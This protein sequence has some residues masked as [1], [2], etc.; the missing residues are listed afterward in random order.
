MKLFFFKS[1]TQL[2]RT[3]QFNAAP[4][5]APPDGAPP[6]LPP[7]DF[8]HWSWLRLDWRSHRMEL[9]AIGLAL[10]VALML[11]PQV[12]N[13]SRRDDY[14]RIMQPLAWGW[15]PLEAMEYRLYDGRFSARGPVVPESKKRIAI[16]AID[17]T[18]LD[19]LAE[20]PWPRNWHARLIGRLKK[21]GAR[22]IVWDVNFAAKQNPQPGGALSPAD[23]ALV[24]ASAEAGNVLISAGFNPQLKSDGLGGT[25][26]TNITAL[27]FDDLDATTPDVGFNWLPTNSSG[28]TRR[29]AWRANVSG[30]DVAGLATLAVGLDAGKLDDNENA[31]FFQQLKSNRWPDARGEVHRV[32]LSEMKIGRFDRV[33]TAPIFFWGPPGTFDTYGYSDVLNGTSGAWSEAALRQK[34]DGRIVFI[35]ATA[36][37]LKDLFVSPA[38]AISEQDAL[39]GLGASRESQVAGV[40]LHAG[41]AAQ[42][43]DG[44]YIHGPRTQSTLA[45]LFGLCVGGA[46]WLAF[47]RRW[48][49]R[50]ARMAQAQWARWRAPGRLHGV[51][52]FG[53]YAMLGGL[54]SL[55]FWQWAQWQFAQRDV[56]IVMIY[57]L[58]GTIA[59]SGLT[60][61]LFFVAEAGERRK[62]VARLSRHV[63]PDV[64]NHVLAHP[65]EENPRPFNAN[66]T[67]LFSDLEGFT[68]Y[69]TSHDA[70]EV[71]EALNSYMTRMVAVVKSHGG[72]L[73]KFMGDGI[74]AFFGAP[75]PRWDHAAQALTCAIAMQNEC[76]RFREETG[77]DFY[78][79]IGVHTGEVIVGYMGS[80]ERA[81]YTVLGDSVNLASRL[82]AKNK[83]LGAR[84]ICS[85]DTYVAAAGAVVASMER[86]T[87]TGLT[88]LIDV[89]IVRGLSGTLPQEERWQR[90]PAADAP[91]EL[92][93]GSASHDASPGTLEGG[94][95]ALMQGETQNRAPDSRQDGPRQDGP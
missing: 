20:W 28:Q 80:E 15:Q 88:D 73:D 90:L 66:V 27:P 12:L 70:A 13:F 64:L 24:A 62:T 31:A 83:E 93:E 34:F 5:G 48:V 30:A 4:D 55:S 44:R 16:V 42:M 63:S 65:E 94:L 22:A 23:R 9:T 35:G 61:L 6:D 51:V 52:W 43:L 54:P 56:W 77:I 76:A 46:L 1:F 3:G 25:T 60:L 87:V 38:F 39:L 11:V 49:S 36:P 18:S 37:L 29:Y 41:L 33:W 91:R 79:R 2:S 89:W 75:A 72:T 69:S 14:E 78:M 53:S 95:P 26:S 17:Q 10:L 86:V 50:I 85:N 57:P 21:A 84:I 74:M 59:S 40:E 19:A 82:E 81:D 7:P 58:L 67:V 47:L 8:D 32:P 92:T 68:R 71:V 45:W